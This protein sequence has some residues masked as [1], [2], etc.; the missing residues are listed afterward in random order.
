MKNKIFVSCFLFLYFVSLLLLFSRRGLGLY[1][2]PFSFDSFMDMFYMAANPVNSTYPPLSLIP[3]KIMHLLTHPD[4][5]Q[6]PF[7]IRGSYYGAFFLMLYIMA[8]STFFLYTMYF[9]VNGEPKRRVF[10]SVLFFFSGIVLFAIERANVMSFAFLFSLL[11]VI[12]YSDGDERKKRMSYVFIAMAISLKLYPGAFLLLVLEKKDIKGLLTVAVDV[13]VIFMFSFVVCKY[14]DFLISFEYNLGLH[15]YMKNVKAYIKVLFHLAAV[16]IIVLA[17]CYVIYEIYREKWK[18]LRLI[19]VISLVVFILTILYFY[20]AKSKNL[21]LGIF[22]VF[23]PVANALRFGNRMTKSVEGINLS[24]KNFILLVNY[25]LFKRTVIENNGLLALCKFF[26]I[27]L[28]LF[29]FFFNKK[30]WRKFAA[31][32]LLCVYVPDFSGMY[33]PLYLFIPLLF[34]IN[35]ADNSKMDCLYAC[36]FAISLTFVIV[37]YRFNI[38]TYYLM[39][40]SF[41]LISLSMFSIYVLLVGNAIYDLVKK[42]NDY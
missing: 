8:F 32:S 24:L 18:A 14:L 7:D 30:K 6:A 12:F 38:P 23:K 5:A 9:S 4:I 41:V 21:F 20:F 13:I 10:Y 42:K 28:G 37:P 34:F 11:F 35:D 27:G 40:G 17:C 26:C 25:L 29:S 33:L 31:L 16:F 36:L 2:H 1:L 3:Y 22:N 15:N 19:A 39:T